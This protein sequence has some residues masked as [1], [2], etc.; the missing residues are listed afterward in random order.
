MRSGASPGSFESV[1][2]EFVAGLICWRRAV[3]VIDDPDQ[4]ALLDQG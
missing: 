4:A 1:A 2:I 3:A